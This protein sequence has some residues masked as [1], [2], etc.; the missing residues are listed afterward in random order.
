MIYRLYTIRTNIIFSI[1]KLVSFWV[2][3]TLESFLNWYI[4]EKGD[5][6]FPFELLV[7]FAIPSVMHI[8]FIINAVLLRLI[9][10]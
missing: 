9:L 7:L 8:W 5:N 2:K 10:L 3:L 4:F 1:N 6:S